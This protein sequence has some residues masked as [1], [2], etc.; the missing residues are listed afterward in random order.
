MMITLIILSLFLADAAGTNADVPP[1]QMLAN[2]TPQPINVD[3]QLDESIW[4][5]APNYTL[6]LSRD[7]ADENEQLRESATV[8][9]AYD[10]NFFYAAFYLTDSDIVQESDKDQQHHYQTGDVAELFLKPNDETWYW[11][12]YVTPNSKRTAFFFPGSGWLG[13]PSC[14]QPHLPGLRVGAQVQGTLN[15]WR[16]RDEAWT[17]EIAVPLAELAEQGIP[18]SPEHPWR[19]FVGRYNYSRYLDEAE[20]SMCPPLS[21]TNYHLNKE[22]AQLVL[23]PAKPE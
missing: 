9:F 8:R 11:E 13:L 22:Y 6:Q 2:H 7:R 18:L 12:L 4:Q 17:A 21:T 23:V 5:T 20:L 15:H 14:F 1:P 3:G 10:E 16:D 19:V